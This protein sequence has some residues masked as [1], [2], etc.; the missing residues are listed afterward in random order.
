MQTTYSL[1]QSM[2]YTSPEK[3]HQTKISVI[4]PAYNEELM[5]GGV[6]K[7][8]LAT[9]RRIAGEFEI[10]VVDDG[11]V[12]KTFD[13]ACKFGVTVLKHENNLGKAAAIKTGLRNSIGEIIVTID[14][15]G[16]HNPDQI[17]EL[18]DPIINEQADLVIGSR[19]L[20]GSSGF[21]I[22]RQIFD[23][24]FVL[25]ACI[26]LGKKLTDTQSGFI[27]FRKEAFEMLQVKSNHLLTTELLIKAIKKGLTVKEVP[28]SVTKR[29]FGSSHV[30]LSY[31][32]R[33]VAIMLKSA[34]G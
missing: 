16:Q 28:V 29:R 5:I 1:E 20:G 27:A 21:G 14:A 15:D 18:L 8:A 10:T 13:A 11:S 32:F 6:V 23:K 22:V 7:R 3:L 33:V 2:R 24:L 31:P 25:L 34:F 30:G 17:P 9:L 19:Y 12:D 26:L 4:I